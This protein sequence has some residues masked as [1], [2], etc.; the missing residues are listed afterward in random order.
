MVNYSYNDMILSLTDKLASAG[1]TNAHWE[2]RELAG[3]ACGFNCR[4]RFDSKTLADESQIK[5]CALLLARRL[6][7]EPL[8]YILGEWDFCGSTFEVGHGVLI[9]RSDTETLIDTALKQFK[10]ESG[11]TVIDLCAGTGCIGITLG[12][13]LDCKE[14]YCVEK[15]ETAMYFLN[16]NIEKH[17]SAVKAVNADVTDPASVKQFPKADLIVSNP[18][19]INAED[20]KHLQREVTFEPKEALAGGED[21]FDFYRA[22]VR[23][24]KDKLKDGGVM[25]FEIGAGQ[26]DEVMEIM[27]QSGLKDVRVRR[28]MAGINRCVTGRRIESKGHVNLYDQLD[29][30]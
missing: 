28:D 13:K 1:I 2:A 14:V 22:I 25:M 27:I 11:I 12:E 21:G 15:Y 19:Y 20:M 6:T 17:G 4:G 30:R 26:E 18:P 24:W 3:F 8:Q 29:K 16:R 7:G 23:L 9:P 10:D 5:Q